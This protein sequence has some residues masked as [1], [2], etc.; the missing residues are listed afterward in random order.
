MPDGIREIMCVNLR[1]QI[2]NFKSLSSLQTKNPLPA[3]FGS[4]FQESFLRLLGRCSQRSKHV[5]QPATSVVEMPIGMVS[6]LYDFEHC[7]ALIP[8]P[9]LNCQTRVVRHALACR[10]LSVSRPPM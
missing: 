10:D 7:P 4:G 5:R 6:V 3:L 1:F 8:D 9:A 2:L